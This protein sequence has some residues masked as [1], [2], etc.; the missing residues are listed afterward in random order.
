M[1]C[2]PIRTR[3]SQVLA[4]LWKQ[5]KRAASKYYETPRAG[6]IKC[7]L[8]L[9]RLQS[10][11]IFCSIMDGGVEKWV[12]KPGLWEIK[13]PRCGVSTHTHIHTHTKDAACYS[14]STGERLRDRK[15][16]KERGR[17]TI[18]IQYLLL[19]LHTPSN[20]RYVS[21]HLYC[22]HEPVIVI[23]WVSAAMI[24]SVHSYQVTSGTRKKIA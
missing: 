17:N 11:M 14:Y 18:A 7:L 19:L 8:I 1:N 15:P 16:Q 13:G 6:A 21:F 9:M 2:I 5:T 12:L 10:E 22:L 4:H 24:I 20:I 23:D 3:T